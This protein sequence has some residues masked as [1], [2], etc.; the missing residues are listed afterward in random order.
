M[1]KEKYREKIRGTIKEMKEEGLLKKSFEEKGLQY[2]ENIIFSAHECIHTMLELLEN[3]N[4]KD[5]FIRAYSLIYDYYLTLGM[6]LM[7]YKHSAENIGISS[8]EI[9]EIDKSMT[10]TMMSNLDIIKKELG[11]K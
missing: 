5:C 10:E 7:L 1:E 8:D 6:L 4:N 9:L 2:M 3:T 11:E